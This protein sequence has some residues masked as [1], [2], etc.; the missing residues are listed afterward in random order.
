MTTNPGKAA[1]AARKAEALEAQAAALPK[2]DPGDWRA[3]VRHAQAADRL[4]AE[5]ARYRGMASRWA[6][7]L[8]A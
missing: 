1:W 2:A 5:A 8:A 7:D 6:P 3:R 4:R